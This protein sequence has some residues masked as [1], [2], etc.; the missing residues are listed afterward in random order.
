VAELL[1]VDDVIAS[2]VA[3]GPDGR[4]TG[5]VEFWSYGPYKAEAMREVAE[6]RGFDLAASYAYSDSFT[7]VPMLECVGNPVAVNPDRALETVALARGWRIVRF[8]PTAGV[9]PRLLA[10]RGPPAAVR[11]PGLSGR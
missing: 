1:G 7:D 8:G 5:E 11:G 4:Y 10:R 2:R 3:L 6:G 9:P